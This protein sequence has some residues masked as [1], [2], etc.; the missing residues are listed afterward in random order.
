MT[1]ETLQ[2]QQD[3]IHELWIANAK[4]AGQ[5]TYDRQQ[6]EEQIGRLWG[7]IIGLTGAL[8]CLAG[9]VLC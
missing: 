1:E 3:A 4:A 7:C 2:A 9:Y 6:F 5:A 8:L